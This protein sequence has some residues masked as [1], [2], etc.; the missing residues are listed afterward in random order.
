MQHLLV[1]H[2]FNTKHQSDTSNISGIK[3]EIPQISLN[4]KMHQSDKQKDGKTDGRAPTYDP[5]TETIQKL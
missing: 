4:Y 3:K 5:C 1:L 2:R